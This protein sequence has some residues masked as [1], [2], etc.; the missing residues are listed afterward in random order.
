MPW[1]GVQQQHRTGAGGERPSQ[2]NFQRFRRESAMNDI[3]RRTVLQ[4]GGPLGAVLALN[5][6]RPALARA[7]PAASSRRFKAID[8]ALLAGVS[9]NDVA[10]V[11][12]VAAT[13]KG[14]VYEGA[15]GK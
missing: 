4:R 6:V 10:G 11:V 2:S 15:F 7:T 12:A 8:A 9:R 13:P 14:M 3:T 5:A 1:R